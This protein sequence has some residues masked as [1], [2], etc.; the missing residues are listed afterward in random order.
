MADDDVPQSGT[1]SE[2]QGGPVPEGMS[3]LMA[4]T[5][6]WITICLFVLSVVAF[7]HLIFGAV[8]ASWLGHLVALG[9]LMII[10]MVPLG[11]F[12]CWKHS[13]YIF[14]LYEISVFLFGLWSFIEFIIGCVHTSN[15]FGAGAVMIVF[16]L[17]G[18]A[19]AG[20]TLFFG[21]KIWQRQDFSVE[22][23]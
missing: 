10:F 19:A 7:V 8:Y 23:L 4:G 1:Q 12:S 13:K 22:W 14:V 20:L 3:G 18:T 21:Y 5:W 2:F 9:V 15:G 16:G 6:K 17:A 11:F